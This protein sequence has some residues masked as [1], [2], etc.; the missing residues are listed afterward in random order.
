VDA[1]EVARLLAAGQRAVDSPDALADEAE[2]MPH[3][4]PLP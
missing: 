3:G 2:V 1:V 4:G